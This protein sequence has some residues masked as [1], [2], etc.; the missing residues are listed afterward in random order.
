MKAP[1]FAWYWNKALDAASQKQF[2][3]AL[4]Y[5]EKMEVLCSH[6]PGPFVLKVYLLY[7]LHQYENCVFVAREAIEITKRS[8]EYSGEEEKYLLCYILTCANAAAERADCAIGF[9]TEIRVGEVDL[10]R[11]RPHVK[12]NFP[13]AH[14][15]QWV[16]K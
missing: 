3:L 15:P 14:H 8:G 16:K 1:R 7:S 5:V 12:R 13:L 4:E 6:V 11:V 2:K 9:E 10:S